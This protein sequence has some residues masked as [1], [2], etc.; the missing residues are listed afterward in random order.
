[1][2]LS[3]LI[4]G[5]FLVAAS[6]AQEEE[7]DIPFGEE[8]EGDFGYDEMEDEMMDETEGLEDL[9]GMARPEIEE[10]MSKLFLLLDKDGDGK[11]T[12]KEMSEWLKRLHPQ[13]QMRQ[14]NLEFEDIDKDKSGFVDLSELH[15][16]YFGED[17]AASAEGKEDIAL[18]FKT[19]DK[20]GDGKLMVGEFKKLLHVGEDPALMKVEIDEI[21]K[22]QDMDG[23]RQI[24]F[25][26]FKGQE[27]GSEEDEESMKKDFDSYDANKDGVID[28]KEIEAIIVQ[29]SEVDH[30]RDVTDILSDAGLENED[31]SLTLATMLE[32]LEIVAQSKLTDYGELLRYPHEY[33]MDLPFDAP[34]STEKDKPLPAAK[35]EG[36]RSETEREGKA[37]QLL[38][39]FLE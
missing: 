12:K 5:A 38:Q 6:V 2:R 11:L 9:L 30:D 15:N 16:A 25:A 27:E 4:F 35:G 28:E 20:D 21:L 33:G 34:E 1:M 10:R 29:H 26:E 39:T 22:Q 14:S 18:R 37:Q 36:G 24:S 31:A 7:D 3:L 23:N 32:K 19:V 8:A 13:V 17:E